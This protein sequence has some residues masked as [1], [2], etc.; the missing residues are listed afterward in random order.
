M[1]Y[2]KYSFCFV[3]CECGP[4]TER[5]VD[6]TDLCG[7]CPLPLV[8]HHP[9]C[10]FCHPDIS[11]SWGREEHSAVE[12]FPSMFLTVTLHCRENVPEIC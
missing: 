6:R 5:E 7:R 2:H 8:L 3:S 12:N 1:N 4:Q 10:R 11:S 9:V